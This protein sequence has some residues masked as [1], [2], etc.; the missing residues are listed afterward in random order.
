MSA[1]FHTKRLKH[2]YLEH[3]DEHNSIGIT[4][5]VSILPKLLIGNSVG[6]SQIHYRMATVGHM[7]VNV[8]GTINPS[9]MVFIIFD[10]LKVLY[11]FNI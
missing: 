1:G 2:L 4:L 5:I 11:T 7:A 8:L 3:I 9:T 10:I 6:M